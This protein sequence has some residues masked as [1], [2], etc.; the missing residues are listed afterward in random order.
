M[1]SRAMS[2]AATP[3]LRRCR[4]LHRCGV[5]V[6]GLWAFLLVAGTASAATVNQPLQEAAADTSAQGRNKVPVMV[7]SASLYEQDENEVPKPVDLVTRDQ[8]LANMHSNLTDV[9]AGTPGFTQIWEYHSP[10]VLRGMNSKRLLVMKN[11]NRKV[12]TFPGGFFGQDLNV[13]EARSTE[14]VKGPGSVIYGSGAISGIVNIVSRSPFGARESSHELSLGYGSNN[15]EFLG[16]FQSSRTTPTGGF[17]LGG[18]FRETDDMTYGNGTIGKNSD[19]QDKDLSLTLGRAVLGGELSLNLD[20]HLGDWGKPRGFNG[21]GKAFTQIRNEEE[22]YHADFAYALPMA[23]W[24]RSLHLTGYFDGGTRDY[25]KYKHSLV[26]DRITGLDLVHYKD[27]YGGG[28]V[29]IVGQPATRHTIT[30]GLDGYLFRLDNPAEIFDYYDDT[31]GVL[32]GY[33]GAGQESF[34]LFVNDELEL[35]PAWRLV[36]G[37]RHDMARVKEGSSAGDGDE[38]RNRTRHATSGNVGVVYSPGTQTH[39]SANLGR[40]FRM[41]TAEEMFTEVIS[42]KGIKLGN[43]DLQPE[44]S[45]NLDLGLRGRAMAGRLEYDLALFYNRLDQYITEEVDREHE[46]VDFTYENTDA[47]IYGGEFSASALMGRPFTPRGGLHAGLGASY[48]YGKDLTGQDD[49][50][51]GIPPLQISWEMKYRQ[52][53]SL[54]WLSRYSVAI[55]GH[56]AAG[57]NRV[58]PVPGG[59][60]GGP[61]GYETSEA[62]FT[63]DAS[64][65][66]ELAGLPG[67]PSVRLVVRNLMDESYWPF[68]SYLPAMGRNFKTV[69]SWAF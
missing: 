54:S 41:P 7:I 22:R 5:A 59:G 49:P 37:I 42:C 3:G 32:P 34:G 51:F 26:Q 44:Y 19:V 65:R 52:R 27:H 56:H 9:L 43:P 58:P 4:K 16:L 1:N 39:L 66:M 18:R 69:V 11:G 12:G 20:Y 35:S 30:S 68:G 55:K 46:D 24:I 2:F 40:A 50:L 45:W 21:P 62:H 31:A 63:L 29:Y 57:Q 25:Y 6:W 38:G 47:V 48:V 53:C 13:Y 17:I 28:R 67:L 10:L 60:D 14:I 8:L 64:L 36:L 15:Q 61:W 33:E 23:G